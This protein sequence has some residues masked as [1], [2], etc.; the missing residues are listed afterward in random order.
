[1]LLPLP[2]GFLQG[3][4]HKFIRSVALR[5]SWG[6]ALTVVFA[7]LSTL[8]TLYLTV[9]VLPE[10]QQR[11]GWWL[12]VILLCIAALKLVA[13]FME[14]R[15]VERLRREM[16]CELLRLFH[17]H[18]FRGSSDFRVT[19]FI[20]DPVATA[21]VRRMDHRT[22]RERIL[23]PL[24]RRQAGRT[25]YDPDSR[26]YYPLSCRA[27]TA[28]AWNRASE[29]VR[30]RGQDP[31]WLTQLTVFETRRQMEDY[32]ENELEVAP[33]ITRRLSDYMVDVLQILSLPIVDDGGDP[34]CLLSVDSRANFRNDDG[35]NGG[36]AQ[37]SGV[38]TIDYDTLVAYLAGVR[39]L[40]LKLSP[41]TPG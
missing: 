7:L 30:R 4:I 27:P 26:I 20:V 21:P 10:G 34:V 40:L 18:V 35:G 16:L 41:G 32:Y 1:M 19:L 17:Q 37:G 29:L 13:L 25:D 9:A 3:R 31:W 28:L 38:V 15:S 23:V 6:A 12:L 2:E 24:L 11:I 8:G 33:E 5:F 14:S 36:A 39:R 22:E